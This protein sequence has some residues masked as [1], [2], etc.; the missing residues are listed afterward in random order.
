[1]TPLESA[2]WDRILGFCLDHGDTALSFAARLAEDNGWTLLYTLRVLDEYRKFAFLLAAAGHMVVPSDAVD[3]AWHLHILYTKSWV[4]FCAGALAMPVQH[5]PA[6]GGGD[7]GERFKT[8]YEQTLGTYR[9]YFGEPPRDIWPDTA[10]R[11]G[12]DLR[13]QRVNLATHFVIPRFWPRR[14]KC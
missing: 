5:E 10:T 12:R 11:F 4:A 14:Q 7:D 13:Y 3:Q 1:M 6:F 8:G 9:R 2:L